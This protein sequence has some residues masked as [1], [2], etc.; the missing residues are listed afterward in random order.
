MHSLFS[1]LDFSDRCLC[2]WLR[3]ALWLTDFTLCTARAST[4][5]Q[6]TH[7]GWN[8]K[9]HQGLSSFLFILFL[10]LCV[11]LL[12][13]VVTRVLER[14]NFCFWITES[15]VQVRLA[16]KEEATEWNICV[17]Y[18]RSALYCGPGRGTLLPCKCVVSLLFRRVVGPPAYQWVD[19]VVNMQPI[20][21]HVYVL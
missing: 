5:C 1:K 12:A 21:K 3:L 8:E 20:F 18:S 2:T 4:C 14:D 15:S 9:V 11:G 10:F 19:A 13:L 7:T 6:L 17:S 16:I